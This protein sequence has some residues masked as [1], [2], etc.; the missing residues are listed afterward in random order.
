MR[1]C[2]QRCVPI[3]GL[4][5]APEASA[6]MPPAA[7]PFGVPPSGG[8]TSKKEARPAADW[9]RAG[10]SPEP[11]ACCTPPRLKAELQTMVALLSSTPG[12]NPWHNLRPGTEQPDA[13]FGSNVRSSAFRRLNLRRRGASSSP[14]AQVPERSHAAKLP[15]PPRLKAELQAVDALLLATRHSRSS[16]QP[17][18][19]KRTSGCPLRLD[20]THK[21][22]SA[23][24]PGFE[25]VS[26]W[27]SQ[28]LPVSSPSADPRG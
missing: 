7:R 5:S 8:L 6:R 17:P 23:V 21:K 19:R 10:R 3:H 25:V 11:P 9:P 26:R 28:A 2:R 16:A 22:S 4:T 20:C 13:P 24:R 12:S 15:T 27:E 1:F 14:Q 18:T